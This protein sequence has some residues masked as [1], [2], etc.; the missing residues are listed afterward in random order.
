MRQRSYVAFMVRAMTVRN[1]FVPR[2]PGRPPRALGA[3]LAELILDAAQDLFLKQGYEATTLEQIAARIGATKRTIYVRFED[4]AQ[5][6]RA[7]VER[8]LD[9]RRPK[10]STIG[11]DRNVEDRLTDMGL[12]ILRYVLEPDVVRVLRVVM[13][14]AY[15]FPE[16]NRAIEEQAAQG[17]APAVEQM[18]EEEVQLGRIE[19]PDV[20]FAT[21]LL[22]SLL[23]GVPARD[24][25]RGARALSHADRRRWVHGAVSLFLDG[26]RSRAIGRC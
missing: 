26:T 4:K 7:V 14:E 11:L 22:L 16:L 10:L 25:G 13:A 3:Q 21:K 6:F 8:V 18:L 19:L 20:R 9:A 15:R 12:A 1:S 17:V 2:G 24:A 5:L 23:T